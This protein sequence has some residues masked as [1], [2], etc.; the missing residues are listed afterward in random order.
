MLGMTGYSFKENYLS[1]VYFSTEI[2]SVNHRFLDINVALPYFLN[3]LEI[4]VRDYI[5]KR[6]CRGKVDV[7]IYIK[8]KENGCAV[9]V[10]L[11]AAK[12]Y[13]DAL[14]SVIS[15][16]N[17][18]DE[19]KLFHLTKFDDI[20]IVDKKRDYSEYWDD[21]EKSL[22]YNIEQIIGMKRT[23][24][25]QTKKDLF[26]IVALIKDDIKSIKDKT[27]ELEKYLYDTIK[28]KVQ[29]MVGDRVDEV[30]LLNEVGILV[31]KGCI[32]E[33]IERLQIHTDQFISISNEDYEV[34]KRL[35]FICQEMHREINTIGSK[36]FNAVLTGNVI[37]IKNN[38]EKIREQI[39]NI[40]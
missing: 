40:E 7:S 33:E 5:K 34:G 28:N 3:S 35:D 22:D 1:E 6:L 2:K 32:N 23:E 14:S 9:N 38:I 39:R 8:I 26:N 31:S 19:V 4:K 21:I 20:F 27:P 18:K 25:D 10:D 24:G 30:R 37:S 36:I 17:I 13:Y 29:E 16:L 12:Q 11:N 15:K